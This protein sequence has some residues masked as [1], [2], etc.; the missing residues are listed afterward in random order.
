MLRGDFKIVWPPDFN[1]S[2][3]KGVLKFR[4]EFLALIKMLRVGRFGDG[5]THKNPGNFSD[6]P[7]DWMESVAAVG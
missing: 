1:S 4:K 5:F 7:F 6:I 3:D 2:F